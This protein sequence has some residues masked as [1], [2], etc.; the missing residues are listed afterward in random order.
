MKTKEQR[1]QKRREWRSKNKER[2]NEASK[3]WR[4]KNKDKVE[5]WRKDIMFGGNAQV[6]L[7]RDNFECQEC[8]MSQEQSIIIFNKRLAIHHIDGNG[9]FTTK[10]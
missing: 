1:N 2:F 7:E 8:G 9:T 5:S 10:S 6:V 4:S 3:V